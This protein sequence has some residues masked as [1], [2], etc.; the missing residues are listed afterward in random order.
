MLAF[1]LPLTE[2]RLMQNTASGV[3]RGAMAAPSTQ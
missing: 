3:Q 1:L 2:M